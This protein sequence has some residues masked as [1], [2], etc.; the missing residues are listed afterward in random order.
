MYIQATIT[1]IIINKKSI[2]KKTKYDLIV[3][4]NFHV[5]NFFSLNVTLNHS[6]YA[7]PVLLNGA[8]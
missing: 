6:C 7:Y 2:N 3:F 4:N 1:N 5:Y 8:K